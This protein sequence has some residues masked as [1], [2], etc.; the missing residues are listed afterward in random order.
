[1]VLKAVQAQLCSFLV[2]SKSLG[3]NDIAG[4]CLG[5]L[6]DEL[7][8]DRLMLLGH[9][10][11]QCILWHANADTAIHTQNTVELRLVSG[12]C[13]SPGRRVSQVSL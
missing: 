12:S 10:M 5:E 6:G 8:R 4:A 1:M 3:R 2:L 7:R 13:E 11:H 9:D